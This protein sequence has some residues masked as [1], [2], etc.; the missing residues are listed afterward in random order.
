MNKGEITIAKFAYFSKA[1]DTIDYAVLIQKLHSNNFSK[2]FL[3]WLVDY[4]SHR[5]RYGQI[6]GKRLKRPYV[7]FG[8]SQGSIL[9]PVLF[10]LYVFDIKKNIPHLISC[11]QYANDST[12]YRHSKPKDI[13]TCFQDINP[14]SDKFPSYRNQ[15]VDLRCKSADWFLYDGN[16]GR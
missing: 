13:N 11:L 1:F 14:L 10:N 15:S 4:L 8:V 6:D 9:K 5:Q 16:I 12:L 7:K 3:Y 2:C